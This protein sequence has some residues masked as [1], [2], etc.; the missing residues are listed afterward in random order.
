MSCEGSS[1]DRG[2]REINRTVIR[3]SCGHR[4]VSKEVIQTG[5]YLSVLGPS[6]VYVRYR[7]GR[8]K[9]V[10]EKLVQEDAWDP[11]VLGASRVHTEESDRHRFR[12]MGEITPEEVIEF[13]YALG[14]LSA[15]PEEEANQH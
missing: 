5:L 10:G 3:C 11:S 8:C 6:F 13:H 12:D 2:Y 1:R 15:D 4:I 14:R 9:R 7:C